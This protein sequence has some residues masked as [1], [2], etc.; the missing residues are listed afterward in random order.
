MVENDSRREEGQEVS[1]Y[2]SRCYCKEMP[3]EEEDV[4]R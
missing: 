4:D 2:L 3:K 1:A